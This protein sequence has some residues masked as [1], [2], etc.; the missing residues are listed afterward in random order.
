MQRTNRGS[1]RSGQPHLNRNICMNAT[2]QKF[3]FL[4]TLA[5]MVAG[6]ASMAAADVT[7]LSVLK[8]HNYTQT[9]AAAPSVSP[10]LPYAFRASVAGDVSLITSA[11]LGTP[12]GFTFPIDDDS[13]GIAK[14]LLFPF[15]SLDDMNGLF[16]TGTYKIT[17]DAENDGPGLVQVPLGTA[18]FP[19]AIPTITNYDEAQAINPASSFT[20]AWNAFTGAAGNDR[21]ELEITDGGTTTIASGPANETSYVIPGG[22]LLEDSSYTAKLRFV[23]VTTQD[24]ASYPGAVATAGFYNETEFTIA[25]GE[26][27]GGGGGN[28]EEPPILVFNFPTNNT[29][30]VPTIS[31]TITF[32][33]SEPMAETHAIQWSDNLNPAKFLYS[34][35]Q[36]RETLLCIYSGGW[37]SGATITWQLNPNPADPNNFKDVAGNLLPP[38]V[39]Q[40][41]FSTSGSSTDPCDGGEV[42]PTKG[43]F[44][45]GK[46]A[47]YVQTNNAAPVIDPENGFYFSAFL[48]M[49]DSQ[50]ASAA[51]ITGPGALNAP[52]Q[53]IF[54]FFS[55][56]SADFATAAA[57]DSAYPQ[58]SY[59]VAATTQSGNVSAA[60]DVGSI[61]TMP[62]PAILNLEALRSMNVSNDFTLQFTPFTG[63]T[64]NDSI[65]IFFSDDN[66]DVFYAPNPCKNIE[67]PVTASSIVI[68]AGTFK[69]NNIMHGGISFVRGTGFNT[70]SIANTFG[71]A[72]LL[73]QTTFD[74]TV[75]P[76]GGG[77]PVAPTWRKPSAINPDGTIDFVLEGETGRSYVI[78]KAAGLNSFT[79]TVGTFPA[80]PNGT[81]TIKVTPQGN[82][83]YRARVQQ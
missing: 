70:N 73:A 67:L 64:A 16:G 3:I 8:A 76:G 30:N 41:S 2:N 23:K 38:L 72:S 37:P 51:R 63:A 31:G 45:L 10:F 50:P 32:A 53:N 12:S 69:T 58:G 62:L 40:G 14:V 60:V 61:A 81:V 54:N 71:S 6:A 57:L 24:T 39:F 48:K 42:D 78:E 59:T 17:V 25:T 82:A 22:T 1:G 77:T 28:D 11:E 7:S 52:M 29:V 44:S 5:V 4:G 49:P 20:L 35:D 55:F 43:S 27:G 46:S 15:L 75:A 34:W 21:Y 47:N 33:F 74:F 66:G 56:T 13:S 83:F 65:Q 18:D 68:P 36:E 26:G 19:A 79:E 9:S 80:S